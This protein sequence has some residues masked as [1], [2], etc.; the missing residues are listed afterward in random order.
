MKDRILNHAVKLAERKGFENLTRRI[1]AESAG[2]CKA[3]VSYHFKSM[4]GLRDAVVE[5]AI[6]LGNLSIIGQAILARHK[7]ASMILPA[8]RI[9]ALTKLAA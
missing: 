1:V 6:E 9:E 7:L 3:S 5:R 2:V 8:V 4:G